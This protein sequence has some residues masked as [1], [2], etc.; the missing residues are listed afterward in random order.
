[1]DLKEWK[2]KLKKMAIFIIFLISVRYKIGHLSYKR[3][4]LIEDYK[5][6][7]ALFTRIKSLLQ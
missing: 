3:K 6:V 4:H 2:I 1:M 5:N 7:Y